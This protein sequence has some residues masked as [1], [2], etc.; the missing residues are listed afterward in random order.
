MDRIGSGTASGGALRYFFNAHLDL[1]YD[2]PR[3][4]RESGVLAP[5]C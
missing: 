1:S 4:L 2:G 3:D 5:L